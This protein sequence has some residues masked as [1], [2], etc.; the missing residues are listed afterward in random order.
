MLKSELRQLIRRRKQ[1]YTSGELLQMSNEIINRLLQ[2]QRVKM[3][4]AVLLYY[5][6]PDEVNTHQLIE[7]LHLQGKTVLLPVIVNET[8]LEL[9]EYTGKE[10]MV[11]G[12]L[13]IEEPVGEPFTNYNIIEV[14]IIPGM[15]FDE[16]GHRL[17]RGKGYYD[18]L[19]ARIPRVYKIGVGFDFQKVEHV[20]TDHMDFN[21]DE[22]I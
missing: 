20:P 1:L 12:K 16:M 3:A 15:G 10:N 4:K 17:G 2:H 22:V 21:M 8:E 9:R 6:L 7:K 13:N 11:K 14:A 5:S 19:L 18:R